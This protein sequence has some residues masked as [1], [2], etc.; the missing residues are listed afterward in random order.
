MTTLIEAARQALEALETCMYPQQKQIQALTSLRQA[1][2]QAEEKN[3]KNC[4]IDKPCIAKG[5]DMQICGAFVPKYKDCGSSP[6][7]SHWGASSV[8]K[9]EYVAAQKEKTQRVLDKMA[10]NARELG[11]DY[12]P[13]QAEKQAPFGYLWPTGRHPEFRFTQQ[14]RDGVEGTPVYTLQP[15]REPP[16]DGFT[17]ALIERDEYH[18][19][20]DEL[21]EIIAHITGEDIGEHTSANFPWRNALDAAEN[22][23]CHPTPP[24]REWVGLTEEEVNELEEDQTLETTHDFISAIE[25]KLKEKNGL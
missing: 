10:E 2:E 3:C 24:Q 23:L 11:L 9:P 18:A 1:I 6:H 21:A 4:V 15:Q 13:V 16:D 22:W 20:A 14:L 7:E 12:E 19:I 17:Q 25:A 5:K 8:T